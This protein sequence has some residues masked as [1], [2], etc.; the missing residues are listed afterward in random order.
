MKLPTN[1]ESELLQSFTK[2]NTKQLY[3]TLVMCVYFMKVIS[4]KNHWKQKLKS[5]IESHDINVTDMGFPVDWQ[6]Q[7]IWT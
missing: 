6:E 2:D 5:L 1:G 4:P 7:P 3:N